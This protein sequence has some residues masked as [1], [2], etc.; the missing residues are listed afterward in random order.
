MGWQCV[1]EVLSLIPM[2]QEAFGLLRASRAASWSSGAISCKNWS[3]ER[4]ES[5]NSLIRKSVEVTP[6]FPNDSDPFAS[7]VQNQHSLCGCDSIRST[8]SILGLRSWLKLQFGHSP[9]TFATFV[10]QR[11]NFSVAGSFFRVAHEIRHF[12]LHHAI[13]GTKQSLQ[14]FSSKNQQ[15]RGICAILGTKQPLW[16]SK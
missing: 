2:V 13:L 16:A 3:L 9:L 5:N 11:G 12:D 1:E 14:T 8:F 10:A 7:S 4:R 6:K 15:S